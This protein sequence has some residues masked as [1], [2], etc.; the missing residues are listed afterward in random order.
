VSL[1]FLFLPL[2][3]VWGMFFFFFFFYLF[4]YYFIDFECKSSF[5]STFVAA[6]F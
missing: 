2:F 1:L 5:I 6:Q 4:Q 3:R